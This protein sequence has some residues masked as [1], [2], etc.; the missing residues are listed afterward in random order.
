MLYFLVL[1]L[2]SLPLQL[3]STSAFLEQGST[4]L[5]V[6]TAVHAGII[7]ALFWTLLGELTGCNCTFFGFG[8][9]FLALLPCSFFLSSFPYSLFFISIHGMAPL[10]FR[11]PD[12]SVDTADQ[13]RIVNHRKTCPHGRL[14][15]R[16]R[17][18]W[19]WRAFSII[20]IRCADRAD[21]SF[22]A[23]TRTFHPLLRAPSS[24]IHDWLCSH[25]IQFPSSFN[26]V[27]RR[28]QHKSDDAQAE[29]M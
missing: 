1:Y 12:P 16:S 14:R 3:I 6:V 13:N 7:A 2:V 29:R 4:G 9:W 5:V 27:V 25:A 15:Q 18:Q 8:F 19:L 26:V 24:S 22:D 23:C 10:G 21:R 17:L 11:G 28:R 20:I